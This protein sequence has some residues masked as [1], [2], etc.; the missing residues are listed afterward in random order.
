MLNTSFDDEVLITLRRIV[1]AIDL[2][3]KK[4]VQRHGITGPQALILKNVVQAESVCVGELAKRVSLS[5]ATVTDILDRLEKRGLVQRTRS[6][7]DKRKVLVQT[8][9]QAR[10]VLRDAPPLLQET[11]MQQ[12]KKLNDWEQT[13]IL[14]SLQRVA[15]MMDARELDA[16]PVLSAG[17]LSPSATDNGWPEDTTPAKP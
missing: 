14:S 2:H 17:P 11:F 3:S 8:T 5:Q 7:T 10:R 9:A 6:S 12:F 16:A 15:W 13:L 4:L 1:R